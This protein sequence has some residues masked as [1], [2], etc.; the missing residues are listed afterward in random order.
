MLKARIVAFNKEVTVPM[1]ECFIIEE[2]PP[3]GW[4]PKPGDV[5]IAQLIDFVDNEEVCESF[6]CTDP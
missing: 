1:A 3:T 4:H 5:V 2:K 6:V